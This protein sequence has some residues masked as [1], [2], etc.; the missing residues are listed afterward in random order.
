MS[1]ADG[2]RVTPSEG[3][4]PPDVC[5]PAATSRPRDGRRRC[6]PPGRVSR[7]GGSRRGL[8]GAARTRLDAPRK[9]LIR[10]PHKKRPAGG[11]SPRANRCEVDGPPGPPGGMSRGGAKR[12][13]RREL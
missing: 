7:A 4:S 3:G 6:F 11:R 1:P 9:H 12:P 10:P 2:D 8:T 13:G 5:P